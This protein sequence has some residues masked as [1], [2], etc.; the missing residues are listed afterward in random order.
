[1]EKIINLKSLEGKARNEMPKMAFDFVA[2][3][4][5]D[6]L[7]LKGNI[8][9]WEEI[10]FLPRMLNGAPERNLKT[11]VLGEPVDFPILMAPMGF[12]CLA[13]PDGE[14]AGAQGANRAGT[15]FALSTTSTKSIEEVSAGCRGPK[16]FQLYVYRDRGLTQSLISRA[17]AAGYKAICLTVDNPIEGR[18]E[19][20][21]INEFHL[22]A[23]LTLAN[24]KDVP[25]LQNVGTAHQESALSEYIKSQWEPALSWQDVDWVIRQTRLPVI[26]K[27]LLS[28]DDADLALQ[29]G[30]AAIIVSNHGGRQLD[31]A[32]A[33]A[34]ALPAIV[35]RVQGR[36]EVLVD[37]GIR[38]GTHVLKA[39]ALGARAVLLGRPLFWG[40]AL[41]GANGVQ[42]VLLH[43]RDE[44]SEAM[45][46]TGCP[47]L[48]AIQPGLLWHH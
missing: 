43:L 37:G 24:F 1:M 40:L 5:E 7:T 10:R 14:V 32:I 38:R 30:A 4:A 41:D 19:R 42:D 9:A 12:Q 11:T 48:E 21:K 25:G 23:G 8:Q 18:R 31:D 47:S 33:T 45:E 20:D 22:P 34:N 27:G 28:P 17:E 3:G 36:C 2:G 46:L 29:H 44:L 13:H 35:E 15:I 39:L 26:V 16:W 6:E